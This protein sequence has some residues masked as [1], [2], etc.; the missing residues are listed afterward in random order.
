MPHLFILRCG[1]VLTGCLELGNILEQKGLLIRE[2][3]IA[4]MQADDYFI[5]TGTAKF[6]LSNHTCKE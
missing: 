2:K 4:V 1:N 6:S 5:T 3:A